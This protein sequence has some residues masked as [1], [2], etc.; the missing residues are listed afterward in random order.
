MTVAINN[1]SYA[2]QKADVVKQCSLTINSKECVGIV[3]ESGSGKTTLLKMMSGLLTPNQGS[4]MIN[5][6]AIFLGGKRNKNLYEQVGVIF[7]DY[8]LFDHLTVV[9]NVALAL[10]LTKKAS[11]E[12]ANQIAQNMLESLGLNDVINQYPFECSG[13]QKQRIA[14]ARALVLQPSILL[15]DE[16]TS[17]LDQDNTIK[18]VETLKKLNQEGLT[19]IVITHDLPF[20]QLVCDRIIEMK[21][22]K[23][24]ADCAVDEFFK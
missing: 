18:L 13:G 7:Q 5:D 1:V 12:K 4:I 20:A 15:V 24:T 9:D 22:G 6:Q 21:Q 10:F 19:I 8:Q 11:K 14:I 3:G 23:I 17:A 2:Y 16:P